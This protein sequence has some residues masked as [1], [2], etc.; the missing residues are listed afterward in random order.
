[1]ESREGTYASFRPAAA[2]R[3]KW[4]TFDVATLAPSARAAAPIMQSM[5]V[6]RRRPDPLHRR[7][8]ITAWSCVKSCRRSTSRSATF[9]SPTS[10]GPHR[11]SAHATELRLGNDHAGVRHGVARRRVVPQV[12]S[13]RSWRAALCSEVRSARRRSNREVNTPTGEAF[14]RRG[15]EYVVHLA[16]GKVEH[17][18][19]RPS[20]RQADY[21][22]GRDRSVRC[23]GQPAVES[24]YARVVLDSEIDA[25]MAHH[26][27]VVE[28]VLEVCFAWSEWVVTAQ[29]QR[30]KGSDQ[31]GGTG[32]GG[33]LTFH[34]GGSIQ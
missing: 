16:R 2:N 15:N 33:S 18:V 20:I 13:W 31:D 21:H 9:R 11:N 7:A 1:M 23:V 26:G 34:H 29:K 19:V 28:S 12:D 24:S 32:D 25:T 22:P 4:A 14:K 5:I 17:I 8:A 10:R 27:D 3:L 6:P 30:S